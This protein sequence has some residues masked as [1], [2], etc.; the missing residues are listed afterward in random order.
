VAGLT[1]V[2]EGEQGEDNQSQLRIVVGSRATG[3]EDVMPCLEELFEDGSGRFSFKDHS[4][5]EPK[6][7]RG[8]FKGTPKKRRRVVAY[9]LKPGTPGE[10]LS[11][12]RSIGEKIAQPDAR[13]T[14]IFALEGDSL[15]IWEALVVPEESADGQVG[16]DG[17]AERLEVI[18][19]KR[20]SKP[21][22]R[23]WAQAQDVHVLFNEDRSLNELIRVTGGWPMLVDRVVASYVKKHDWREVIEGLEQWLDSAE[24]AGAL[25]EAIGLVPDSRLAEIW[26]LFMV[27]DEPIPREEFPM[28]AEDDGIEDAARG[29]EL[30]RSMQVL[31]LDAK[32]RYVVEETAAR[33]WRRTRPAMPHAA[34]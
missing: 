33:A 29:A 6:R 12:I 28:L 11:L 20:W 23:A 8:R 27:Y 30:L 10:A 15:P 17:A 13:S 25:C 21:G 16:S 5:L 4:S 3:I 31:E 14:V 26:N 19:L 34:P 9:R 24:G 2:E 1:A 7:L 32:G 22:L 18:E